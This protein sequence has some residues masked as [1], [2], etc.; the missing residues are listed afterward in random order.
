MLE[1]KTP[2]AMNS[3]KNFLSFCAG[4]ARKSLVLLT[5]ILASNALLLQA[6]AAPTNPSTN[7]LSTQVNG[8]FVTYTSPLKGGVSGNALV[9]GQKNKALSFAKPGGTHLIVIDLGK[10]SKL[11]TV[12][13]KFAKQSKMQVFVL[14]DKPEGNAWS[15]S[16]SGLTPDAVLSKSDVSAQLNG[17]E[18]QYLVLICQDDPG[19]FSDL[20]VTGL[21]VDQY[22]DRAI[23][24]INNHG[25]EDKGGPL[26]EVPM[27][28]SEIDDDNDKKKHPPFVPHE[29]E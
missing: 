18:G 24:F 8:A 25:N 11:N 19:P 16:I 20:V 26:A 17:T 29:S 27:S 2:V 12:E 9:S 23:G 5:P 7:N 3:F 4:L 6:Q 21:H 14:K 1:S 13:L 28:K 15:Q 22:Q 10:P